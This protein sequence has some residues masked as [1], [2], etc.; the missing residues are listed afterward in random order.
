[1]QQPDT[2]VWKELL[3]KRQGYLFA[4]RVLARI[5]DWRRRHQKKDAEEPEQSRSLGLSEHALA[6]VLDGMNKVTN[7]PEGTAYAARI[8]DRSMAMGGKSGTAQVRRISKYERE[9]RVLK[10]RER[11]WRERDHALFVGYAPVQAPRYA[12]AVVVEHGGGGS[13]VAGPIARDILE[14]TQK[15]DPSRTS[16]T[17]LA[18]THKQGREEG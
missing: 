12:V 2:N 13:S 15:S 10:N 5:L 9:T 18:A 1:M 4:A 6:V 11:Q 7:S 16:P 3:E 17:G 8:K 14:A